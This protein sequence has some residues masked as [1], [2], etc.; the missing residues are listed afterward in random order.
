M[1][2]PD[3]EEMGDDNEK[4]LHQVTVSA[5]RIGVTPVTVELYRRVMRVEKDS[6]TGSP[7]LPVTGV[8]WQDAIIK[9]PP[10]NL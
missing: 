5:F 4:P 10:K 6:G 3:T 9:I 2:L 1:G 7:I 8:S